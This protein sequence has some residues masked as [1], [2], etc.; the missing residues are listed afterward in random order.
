MNKIFKKDYHLRLSDFDKYNRIKPAA[1]LELFQDAAGDHANELG[2]G[3][4][5][6][7]SR[8]LFWVIVRVKF[9]I[10]SNP[11]SSDRVTVITWPIEPRRLCYPREFCIVNEE[12]ERLV[13]GSSDW[14]ILNCERRR[15]VAVE[16]LY[17][18]TDGYHSELI[19]GER[20]PGVPNFEAS[21]EP[22]II[23]P[24]FSDIDHNNHVNNTRYA[25]YVMDAI[26]PDENEVLEL[27]QIDY[28]KEVTEGTTLRLYSQREENVI[29]SRG[30]CDSGD[31]MF[32][33]RL[34]Y[35]THRR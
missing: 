21:D 26:A 28:R 20:A 34:E 7:L 8:S 27:F 22:R 10:I 23:T 17:P 32:A 19:F 24:G 12:G 31:V 25:N 6:M 3:R 4:E 13:E 30:V 5:N 18:F 29:L 14:A 33:C 2:I 15:L 1:V 11:K 35:K 9:R 16:N